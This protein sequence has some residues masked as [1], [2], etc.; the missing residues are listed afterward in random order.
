MMRRY[1]AN[2]RQPA[3]LYGEFNSIDTVS[4]ANVKTVVPRRYARGGNHG[5]GSGMYITDLLPKLLAQAPALSSIELFVLNPTPT[6]G[7]RVVDLPDAKPIVKEALEL[8][9]EY[10]VPFWEA[11]LLLSRNAGSEIQEKV[12]DEAAHHQS[13]TGAARH[14]RLAASELTSGVLSSFSE[15]LKER[16]TLLFSSRI[17]L[18]SGGELHMPML[19]F[20]IRPESNNERLAVGVIQRI[21]M[22]GTLLNS[23]NSFHFYGT[24][25]LHGQAGLAQ[26]LGTA[27]LFSPFVDQRW[28]GHQMI[29]GACALRVS[30]GKT[31]PDPPI[32]VR[33][34]SAGEAWPTG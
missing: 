20:R 16:Q 4:C 23:G 17:S 7:S 2:R 34:I 3:G 29:E 12:L 24:R 9:K 28:I 31:F 8:R 22:P 18:P 19:D 26:F 1:L 21:K 11:V 14:I 32:V 13:M 10:R 30:A 6:T 15:T 33:D 27:S 5:L 25:L